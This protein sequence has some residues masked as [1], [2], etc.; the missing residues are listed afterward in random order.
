M[1]IAPWALE[2]L[3]PTANSEEGVNSSREGCSEAFRV[4]LRLVYGTVES[5]L[6]GG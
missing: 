3:P 2:T 1:R 4:Y 6:G 5:M